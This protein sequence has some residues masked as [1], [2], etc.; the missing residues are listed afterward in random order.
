MIVEGI[1]IG[2]VYQHYK[3][4]YYKVKDIVYD[5][6]TN[7]PFVIYYRCDLQGIFQSI[8]DKN[9]NVVVKQPFLRS[10]KEFSG[11][12]LSHDPATQDFIY[13]ERFKL[14]KQEQFLLK[15][16]Y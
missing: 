13:I 7:E 4:N 14:L 3:G 11:D 1:Q 9:G 5:H 8:R 10:I 15:P 6:E 2:G 12:I 16:S